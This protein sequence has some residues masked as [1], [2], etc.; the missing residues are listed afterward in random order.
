MWTCGQGDIGNCLNPNFI[1]RCG[2]M[3]RDSIKVSRKFRDHF[4]YILSS[5]TSPI[6]SLSQLVTLASMRWL[7]DY[8][9]ANPN[10]KKRLIEEMKNLQKE[11]EKKEFLHNSREIK[12]ND[13]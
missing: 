12:E 11:A 3:D 9:Q 7:R 4:K 10:E 1:Y 8:T 2:N 6:K 5:P 13:E